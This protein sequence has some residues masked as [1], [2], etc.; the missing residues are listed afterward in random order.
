MASAIPTRA[1]GLVIAID[2]PSGAGKSTV[3]HLLAE[4]LG[5]LQIDTGAMYRA[6]AWSAACRRHRSR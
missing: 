4:R 1:N 3:A 2:G 6:V 5:Y